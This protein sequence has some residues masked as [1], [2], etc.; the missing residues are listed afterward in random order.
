MQVAFRSVLDLVDLLGPSMFLP[1]LEDMTDTQLNMILTAAMGQDE[2][3]RNYKSLF[4]NEVTE[5]ETFVKYM[6]TQMTLAGPLKVVLSSTVRDDGTEYFNTVR[7]QH[8]NDRK[9]E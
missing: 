8:V 1:D 4:G 2:L 7:Y 6:R 9:A 3:W 5:E